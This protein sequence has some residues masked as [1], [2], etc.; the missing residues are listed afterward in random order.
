MF[1]YPWAL[2]VTEETELADEGG[3]VVEEGCPWGKGRRKSTSSHRR[4]NADSFLL[5][6]GEDPAPSIHCW[7]FTVSAGPHLT[8]H[9]R[10]AG[11]PFILVVYS[12][13]ILE[14][15]LAFKDPVVFPTLLDE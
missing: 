12:H 15:E 3:C 1:P 10:L 9:R 5:S 13:W 4:G 8:P 11:F 7:V 14:Q 6:T 2:C